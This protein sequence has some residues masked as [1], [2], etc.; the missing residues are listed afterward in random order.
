MSIT[1]PS[2]DDVVALAAS[3]H[4]NMSREEAAEQAQEIIENQVEHYMGWL[5]S[6]EAVNTI[7]SYR[8]QAEQLRDEAIQNARRQLA[9]G[10]NPELVVTELA[11]ILTQKLL[12]NPTVQ[13]NRAA[14]EG[15]DELLD[16]VRELF[17]LK[18]NEV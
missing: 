5:R 16:T 2:V 15:R 1:R 17:N 4:M 8:Q 10:K 9:A 14:F 6:L 13:M 12:H 11:R 18:D 7:R 3:L